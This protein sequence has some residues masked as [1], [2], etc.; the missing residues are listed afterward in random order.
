MELGLQ[1]Q[2]EKLEAKL[3]RYRRD[4]E[5]LQ[6]MNMKSEVLIK[7][8]KIQK[9]HKEQKISDQKNHIEK[10]SARIEKLKDENDFN[11]RL[12]NQDIKKEIS[13]YEAEIIRLNKIVNDKD[14]ELTHIRN[15]LEDQ[16]SEIDQ[17]RQ[18][19]KLIQQQNDDS[20][21]AHK[22]EIAKSNKSLSNHSK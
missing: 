15:K 20:K 16:E 6:D 5:E 22:L 17:C 12:K 11:Q 10:S 21:K 9:E 13:D 8:H 3:K 19:I 2:I 14:E 7:L 18:Q 1:A 4:N